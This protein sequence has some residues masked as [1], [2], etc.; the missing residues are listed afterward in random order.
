[1][2]S[3]FPRVVVGWWWR[4]ILRWRAIERRQHTRGLDRIRAYYPEQFV[5]CSRQLPGANRTTSSSLIHFAQDVQNTSC[6]RISPVL[7]SF[8]KM[9]LPSASARAGSP[10]VDIAALASTLA[11]FGG[12]TLISQGRKKGIRRRDYLGFFGVLAHDLLCFI[13]FCIT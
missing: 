12:T 2:M 7:A 8:S 10:S 1:M 13:Q 6:G 3:I 4:V 5:E 11:L 9:A